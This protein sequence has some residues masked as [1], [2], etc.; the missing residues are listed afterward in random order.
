MLPMYEVYF[1]LSFVSI[2]TLP[3]SCRLLLD[4]TVVTNV[5]LPCEIYN[6]WR[7]QT[8]EDEVTHLAFLLSFMSLPFAPFSVKVDLASAIYDL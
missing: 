5:S 8:L 4:T 2:L 1:I 3:T 6:L 7:V